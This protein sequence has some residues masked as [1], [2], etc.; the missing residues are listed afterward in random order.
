MK[1][2]PIVFNKREYLCPDWTLFVAADKTGSI[3]AFEYKPK[4]SKTGLWSTGVSYGKQIQIGLT[5]AGKYDLLEIIDEGSSKWA[6][7]V[8][9]SFRY[10]GSIVVECPTKLDYAKALEVIAQEVDE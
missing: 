9:K 8:L 4:Q 6:L 7:K 10:N 1:L 5:E 2:K 3:K